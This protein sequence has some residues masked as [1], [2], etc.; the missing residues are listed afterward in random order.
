ML[1][2][3][4]KIYCFIAALL[5]VNP[6]SLAV[7]AAVPVEPH[8]SSPA[9]LARHHQLSLADVVRQTMSVHFGEQ[10]LGQQTIDQFA[11][12]LPV[13]PDLRRPAGVF[14]TLSYKGK[15]RACWGS[16]N[17]TQSSLV[18]QT[19]YTTIDALTKEYRYPLIKKSEWKKLKPQVS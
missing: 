6:F 18:K 5:L 4:A 9:A 15:S 14:V 19:V 7:R 3:L 8:K 2:K 1:I 11:E 16:I 17:P 12:S 10:Q 13:H